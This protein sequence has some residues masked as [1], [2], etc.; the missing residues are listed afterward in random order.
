MN[1]E[2]R[3][4]AY[5]LNVLKSLQLEGAGLARMKPGTT[6]VATLLCQYFLDQRHQSTIRAQISDI[7][8]TV[9]LLPVLVPASCMQAAPG[10]GAGLL[11]QGLEWGQGAV[12]IGICYYAKS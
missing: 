9:S 6:T 3:K 11:R 12:K 1:R 7:W 5:P 8:R 10:M 4:G 2:G